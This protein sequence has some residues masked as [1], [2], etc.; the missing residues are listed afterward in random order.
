VVRTSRTAD[1]RDH[2][3]PTTATASRPLPP[4]TATPGTAPSAPSRTTSSSRTRRGST[5]SRPTP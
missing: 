3:A 4:R 1:R 2:P 5:G